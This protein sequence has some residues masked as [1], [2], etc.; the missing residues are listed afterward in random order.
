MPLGK[1]YC[2]YCDKQFQDTPVARKRHLSG[3]MH[4]RNRALWYESV[5][6]SHGA[7]LLPQDASHV[8]DSAIT[9]SVRENVIMVMFIWYNHPVYWAI[10]LLLTPLFQEM[11]LE[12]T[13][14]Y[15][16]VTYLHLYGLLQ[17]LVIFQLLLWTGDS[18]S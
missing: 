5:E 6:D 3:V 13:W 4:Q 7:V 8:K 2:D 16:G 18:S 10:H 11:L 12:I 1:Y 14:E 17:K 15:R 9:F